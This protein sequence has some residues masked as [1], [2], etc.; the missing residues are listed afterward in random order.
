M[1][2]YPPRSPQYDA[3]VLLWARQSEL[4]GG[5]EKRLLAAVREWIASR[6]PFEAVLYPGRE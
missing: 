5:L 1:Y 3:E 4:A 6:W 2:I